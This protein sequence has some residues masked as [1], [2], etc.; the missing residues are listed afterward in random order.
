MASPRFRE[1]RARSQRL[2]RLPMLQCWQADAIIAKCHAAQMPTCRLKVHHSHT[3][4]INNTGRLAARMAMAAS[5][6]S[7]VRTRAPNFLP[8]ATTAARVHF[9]F[10]IV[11]PL[12]WRTG[13]QGDLIGCCT[14]I[15][16]KLRNSLFDGL[17]WLCLAAAL[18]LSFSPFPVRKG[19]TVV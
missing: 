5:N 16:G 18:Q 15:G 9:G 11:S 7:L 12:T 13:L 4:H 8:D 17:T 3:I 19:N 14:E 1:Y 2:V 10:N 6:S